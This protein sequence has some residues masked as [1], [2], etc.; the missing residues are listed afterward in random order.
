VRGNG[1]FVCR[2]LYLLCWP[3]QSIRSVRPVISGTVFFTMNFPHA[4]FSQPIPLHNCI[5][6]H[7]FEKENLIIEFLV[8]IELARKK[9]LLQVKICWEK[10]AFKIVTHQAHFQ[11]IYASFQCNTVNISKI[12]NNNTFFICLKISVL[13]SRSRSRIISV[14]PEP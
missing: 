13:Q 8:T 4:I 14:L 6:F 1:Y 3:T 12:I 2:Q 7:L 11:V 9:I 10:S 5:C